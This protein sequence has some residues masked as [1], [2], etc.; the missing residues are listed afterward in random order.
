MSI[1]P[2][3]IEIGKCYLTW[4]GRVVQVF[5]LLSHGAVSYRFRKAHAEPPIRWT[6]AIA[7]LAP[8]A[9][10]VERE[11]PCDWTPETGEPPRR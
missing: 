3:K 5:Q 10:S 11:V 2:E 8:I 6:G 7:Y 4:D 9:S 1:P